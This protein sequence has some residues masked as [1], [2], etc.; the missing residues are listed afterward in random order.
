MS[1]CRVMTDWGEGVSRFGWNWWKALHRG[2][3][4]GDVHIV[5]W[6]SDEVMEWKY[7]VESGAKRWRGSVM[8]NVYLSCDDGW[9][10]AACQCLV[11]SDAKRW[12][13]VLCLI[14]PLVMWWWMRWWSA[15]VWLKVMERDEEECYEECPLVMW[16]WMRWWSVNVWSKVM[17]WN[18]EECDEECTPVMWL[19]MR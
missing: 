1:T 8:K 9:G 17:E 10:D 5:M 16:W 14:C 15:N 12:R 2:V 7:L 6:W 18:D 19:C 3:S 11:E 13:G 4:L